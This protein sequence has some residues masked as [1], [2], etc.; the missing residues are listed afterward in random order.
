MAETCRCK[1]RFHDLCKRFGGR[2]QA[3][4]MRK[5]STMKVKVNDAMSLAADIFFVVMFQLGRQYVE[6]TTLTQ[7]CL[8]PIV[9]ERS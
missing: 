9:V 6:G 7:S 1:Q 5:R 8:L 2:H 3:F 4:R